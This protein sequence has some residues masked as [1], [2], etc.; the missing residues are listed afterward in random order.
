MIDQTF[1]FLIYGPPGVGKTR[2]A[3]TVCDN[4][5]M[6]KVLYC[7]VE[8]GSLSIADRIKAK[9]IKIVPCKSVKELEDIGWKLANKDKDYEDI[10]TVIIDTVNELQELD[11][12]KLA[13]EGLKNPN[14]KRTSLDEPN[15]RDFGTDTT[16]LKRIFRMFRDLKVN[17]IFLAHSKE[18][19]NENGKIISIMPALTTKVEMVLS[20]FVDFLWYLG[21]EGSVRKLALKP[22]GIVRVKTRGTVF[23]DKVT[24]VIENPN[25]GKIF[26]QILDLEYGIKI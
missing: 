26:D 21:Q 4:P 20:S 14:S 24:E 6:G 5:R 13:E 11:L 3:A 1:N 7:D 2:L 19:K 23:P 8:N 10:R 22:V 9:Q 12:N 15:L 25:I 18:I 16:R 17:V